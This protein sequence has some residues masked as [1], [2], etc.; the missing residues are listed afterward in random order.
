MASTDIEAKKRPKAMR[1]VDEER[2]FE[3]LEFPAGFIVPKRLGFGFCGGLLVLLFELK[4]YV[5]QER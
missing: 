1:S 5:L 3:Y 4:Q 2:M